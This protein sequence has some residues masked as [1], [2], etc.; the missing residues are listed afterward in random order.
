MMA[1]LHYTKQMPQEVRVLYTSRMSE[2]GRSD[3][4]FGTRLRRIC[5]L[6]LS[7]TQFRLQ[8]Y[9]TG[10]HQLLPERV[11]AQWQQRRINHDDLI[12][13]IG[14]REDRVGVVCYVCGPPAMTDDFVSVL[15]HAE[16]M[17]EHRVLC[18]KWW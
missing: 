14:S 7:R 16:G 3:F 4:L 11:R 8:F 13:A 2:S 15:R 18:E 5:C 6:G 10:E 17:D 12:E 1:H 9:V